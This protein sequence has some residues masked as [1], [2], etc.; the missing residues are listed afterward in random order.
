MNTILFLTYVLKP[1]P[2]LNF[3]HASFGETLAGSTLFNLPVDKAA[4]SV[5]KPNLS[6]NTTSH[7]T[8]LLPL[9]DSSHEIE[10]RQRVQNTFGTLTQE[11]EAGTWIWTSDEVNFVAPVGDSYFRRSYTPPAGKTAVLAEILI[12]VDNA[13]SL[14]V[15][16]ALVGVSPSNV[17]S[18]ETAQGYQ[19]ALSPGPILFAVAATNEASATGG[20][21]AAG[22]LAAIRITFSDDTQVLIGTDAQWVSNTQAIPSFQLPSTDDS[23]WPA[24]IVLA[25]YGAGP[26]ASDVTLPTVLDTVTLPATS[27]SGSVAGTST[28]LPGSTSSLLTSVSSPSVL[29]TTSSVPAVSSST[30]VVTMTASD[31]TAAVA[32]ATSPASASDA[33][34]TNP[35]VTG[36]IIGG[37][38]GALVIAGLALVFWRRHKRSQEEI[39]AADFDTWVPAS[40]GAP[41]VGPEAGSANA[42]MMTQ[43]NAREQPPSTLR[44]P[45]YSNTNNVYGQPQP[46][47][48]YLPPSMAATSG[49][50]DLSSYHG[51]GYSAGGAHY[52]GAYNPS[53][54]GGAYGAQGGYGASA[55]GGY[56]PSG[57]YGGDSSGYGSTGYGAGQE[58]GSSTQ[59]IPPQNVGGIPRSLTPGQNQ[60]SNSYDRGYH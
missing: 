57:V 26:W 25:K 37:V 21:N 28:A 2:P 14:F 9:Q 54:S 39:S 8:H 27:T 1:A 19:M 15:N 24:A 31:S 41:P 22:V 51:S 20:A 46:S 34:S 6:R 56:P 12:T 5:T 47:N 29:S 23:T 43:Q 38:I 11:F 60:N 3:D 52:N 7:D 59:L 16:G 32:G 36:G 53:A 50:S 4:A 58:Y 49:A 42:A 10:R 17:D 55:G 33:K 18:W 48:R 13:Y 44:Q 35:A 45:Q 40:H 30:V